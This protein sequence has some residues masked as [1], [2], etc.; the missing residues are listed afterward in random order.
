MRLRSV[1][2]LRCLFI[3]NHRSGLWRIV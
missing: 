1:P 2:F 3:P